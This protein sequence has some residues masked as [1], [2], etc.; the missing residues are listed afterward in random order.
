VPYGYYKADIGKWEPNGVASEAVKKIF[1][2]VLSGFSPAQ[3]RDKLCAEK[4]PTPQEY[5]ELGRGKN[6]TPAFLWE[7]RA[8]TRILTNIQY[9]GTYVSGKQ[10]AK[11][12]GS[13]SKN[14]NPKSE[15]IVIP[16]KHTPIIESEV[17]DR[18]QEI[19]KTF[20]A[21]EP[22]P[23]SAK[24][25]QSD[26]TPTE[27]LP[28]TLPY[29][30]KFGGKG[31]WCLDEIAAKAV[32]RI[33]DLSL[34]G[35]FEI[36]I[37]ETLKIEGFPTPQEYKSVIKK[38][39]KT[40]PVCAW[41]TKGVRDILRDIQY[42]GVQVCGK[43]GRREDG[44]HYRTHESDWILV[45]DRIP[46]IVSR[47]EYDAV[48]LFIA[49]HGRKRGTPTHLLRGNIVKCGCCGMTMDYDKITEP[50]Y[51]CYFTA[52]NPNAKCYKMKIKASFLDKIVLSSIRK[53][54]QKVFDCADLQKLRRK[55]ND[56]QKIEN[57][58]TAIKQTVKERQKLYEQ[59]VLGELTREKY[60]ELKEECNLRISRLNLQFSAMKSEIDS[61]KIN[62][63]SVAV[64]KM[65][66]SENANNRELVETLI[67][68][69]LV[70][71]N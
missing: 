31:I 6:I 1:D 52:A 10:E 61:E 42:T 48:N 65:A 26:F 38:G 43:F 24:H 11:A 18:V 40:A 71:P 29:G 62:P 9:K 4:I 21:T 39:K 50:V 58:E 53:K 63:R 51:R 67:D 69:V 54:A 27:H 70:Y 16:D 12:I 34:Q 17:F 32:R 28:R 13:S 37:A 44:T 56:E 57:C 8:V 15:W 20:L 22:T 23:K 36:D 35:V 46:A 30:Y 66:V 60:L 2:Y 19:M 5:L 45:P 59:Y 47:E 49:N 33:F 7:A 25:C 3:I 41:R 55:D 64:A 68:S 14:R